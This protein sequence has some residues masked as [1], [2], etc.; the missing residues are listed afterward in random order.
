MSLGLATKGVLCDYIP[1]G[2]G[3]GETIYVLEEF[4]VEVSHD[5]IDIE[6]TEIEDIQVQVSDITISVELEDDEVDIILSDDD[7]NIEV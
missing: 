7:I 6:V 1:T 2:T 5:D 3:S 4:N